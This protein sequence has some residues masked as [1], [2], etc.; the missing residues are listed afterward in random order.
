MTSKLNNLLNSENSK[1]TPKGAVGA[2]LMGSKQKIQLLVYDGNRKSMCNA[3]ITPSFNFTVGL[4]AKLIS[5]IQNELYGSFYDDSKQPF[6]LLFKTTSEIQTFS[7]HI[8]LAKAG[9]GGFKSLVIQ[10]IKN[11]AQGQ[12]QN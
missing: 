9:L 10:D 12:V 4:N 6:A 11:A 7:T 1:S 3:T 2:A 5:K 8:A